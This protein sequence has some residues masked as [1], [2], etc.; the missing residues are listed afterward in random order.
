MQLSPNDWQTILKSSGSENNVLGDKWSLVEK[1]V[2]DS[3]LN[4]RYL[5]GSY[6]KL[7]QSVADYIYDKIN[8]INNHSNYS[9]E[10]FKSVSMFKS[11]V[12][13]GCGENFN[14]PNEILNIVRFSRSG[15]ILDTELHHLTGSASLNALVLNFIRTQI[16]DKYLPWTIFTNGKNYSP[17][18][19]QV[20]SFDF[21]TLCKDQSK[22]VI[23]NQKNI[24][25]LKHFLSDGQSFLK[26]L[27]DEL[28]K[29]SNLD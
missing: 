23:D 8:Q 27:I 20:N 19:G 13:E 26:K 24:D 7:E 4:N 10:H 28:D 12:I 21:L 18:H 1:P 3:G 29:F 15:S 17:K 6:A 14:N 2:C 16:S 22:L 9:L 5:A 11:A 25:N